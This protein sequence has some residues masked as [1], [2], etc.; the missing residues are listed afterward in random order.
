MLVAR[1]RNLL[2]SIQAKYKNLDIKIYEKDLSIPGSANELFD[3]ITSEGISIDILIN[4][5]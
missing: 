3:M 2:E 4:N 5:A 1:R